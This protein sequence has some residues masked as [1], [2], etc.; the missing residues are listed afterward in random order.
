MA[1][2]NIV[3]K[4]LNTSGEYDVL[5]PQTTFEQVEGELDASRVTGLDAVTATVQ[6]DYNSTGGEG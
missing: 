1:E 6:K 5:Y 4:Q 2:K 3:M